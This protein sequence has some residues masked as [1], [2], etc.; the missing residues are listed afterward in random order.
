MPNCLRLPK[1]HLEGPLVNEEVG[2]DISS[3]KDADVVAVPEKDEAT[4]ADEKL[5]AFCVRFVRLN[6][7]LFTR[8]R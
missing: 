2:Q 1:T 7:I 3:K 8:T 6:G 5:K 4:S